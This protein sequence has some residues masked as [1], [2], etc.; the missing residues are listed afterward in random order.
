M[1]MEFQEKLDHRYMVLSSEKITYS[2]YQ[3][4]MLQENQIHG[5]LGCTVKK[6]DDKELYTYDVTGKVSLI[7]LVSEKKITAVPLQSFFDDMIGIRQ[8]LLFDR[9][10]VM[11]AIGNDHFHCTIP[12]LLSVPDIR[13]RPG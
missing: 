7:Q 11:V 2:D 13:H 5:L 9:D 6:I 1:E 3:T 8:D 12:F 10:T 4:H